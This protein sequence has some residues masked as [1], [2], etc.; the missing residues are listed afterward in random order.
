MGV[1]AE[2]RE[3]EAKLIE[4]IQ[5]PAAVPN[6]RALFT[7]L[8][9]GLIAGVLGG[10]VA[11]IL[12]RVIALIVTGR[13]EFSIGGTL[14]ILMIGGLIGPLFGLIYRSTIFKLNAPWPMKGLFYSLV[15]LIGFQLPALYVFLGLRE[16]LMI[17]GPLGFPIFALMNFSFT[18]ILAAA[19]AWLEKAWNDE[20]GRERF[21]KIAVGVLGLMAL[22][23]LVLL[24]VE[25]VEPALR[26]LRIEI[27]LALRH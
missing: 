16:E 13:G 20:P 27:I 15:L 1:K 10:V 2:N 7:G 22:A 21:E 18:L 17:V 12:M 14:G 23:S 6:Q 11:R 25:F 26:M 8:L 9:A 5:S 3:S 19:T 24:L 4:Q